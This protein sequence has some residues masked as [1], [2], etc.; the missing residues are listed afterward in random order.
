MNVSDDLPPRAT[1]MMLGHAASPGLARG[2]ALMCECARQAIVPRRRVSV[3]ETPKEMERFDEAVAAVEANL[4]QVEADVRRTL[5]QAEAEIFGVQ[6]LMLR[7]VKLREAVREL[8]SGERVNVE[9]AVE[10]AIERLI[11]VFACME[12]P[13]LRERA[14]DLS[15]VGRRLLDH[16]ANDPQPAIPGDVDGC[17]LVASE[18]FSSAV[19]GLAGRGVRALIIERG[20]VTAHATIL[21][22]AL[23]IPMLVHV[24]EATQRI[25]AGDFVIVDALAGRAFTNPTAQILR[26]YDELEADLH[27]HESALGE[28]IGLPAVTRDGVEIKLSANIG[29]TADAVAAACVK[30]D[31]TGLYRTEFIFLVQDHFPSEEEQFQFY[32]ATAE[33]LRPGKT[34][35]RVLDTGSDKPL[36]YFPM[37][38]EANP[39][40][41]CRGTR[42]LLAHPTILR[43]QLRAILRVSATHPVAILLPMITGVDELRAVKA[44]IE[45]VK[46][47]L[48][49]AGVRFDACIQVGAMIETPAAALLIGQ[50]ADEADFFSVGT[51]DL[52]QYLLAADR[53]GGGEA[54]DPLHP[55]VLHTLASL[56]EAADSAGKPISLCGEIASD[57]LYTALLLGLGFRRFSVTSGRL[58]E[59]KYAIRS[60][61][62][63]HAGSL[64]E[65]VLQLDTTRDI[66]T[67]V[68]HEWNSRRPVAA[69]DFSL[70]E[71]STALPPSEP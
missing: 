56:A 64:A 30:P 15:E 20:G 46:A 37:P 35:I 7:E 9:V 1:R 31:G 45:A 54:Y 65:R 34:V 68:E 39:A 55:A 53:D 18:L 38:R 67:R 32:W 10:Q 44:V 21:A 29:Q 24:A 17:V 42:L 47:E 41:G 33:H 23:G 69:P 28:L 50:L 58:L 49:A 2:R 63:T 5:G 6:I 43:T 48:A 16:F 13:Y 14:A 11:A 66:R 19:A 70:T 59:I 3:E 36:A 27:A 61:D 26:K 8:C 4:A 71:T 52:V 25:R 62:L 22:R 40:L 51:N 60:I 57:P 12:D